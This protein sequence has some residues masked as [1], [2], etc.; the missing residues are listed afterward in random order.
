MSFMG[1]VGSVA[2]AGQAGGSAPSG[3]SIAST[4]PASGNYDNACVFAEVVDASAPDCHDFSPS[5][6]FNLVSGTLVASKSVDVADFSGFNGVAAVSDIEIRAYCRA[7]NAT[8]FQWTISIHAETS[9]ASGTVAVQT[10]GGTAQDSTG[11]GNDAVGMV[12]M[13]FGG[14]KAGFLFPENDDTLAIQLDCT[15]TNSSGS[16]N[17]VPIVF[18]FKYQS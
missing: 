13:T 12:R 6:S 17:A 18:K 15:A 16:T 7:T 11:Q 10:A 1:T 4:P 2:Q 14:S 3:V 8:S 9:I 5:A